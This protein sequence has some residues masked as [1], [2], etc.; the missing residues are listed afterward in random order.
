MTS[1][2]R[3]IFRLLAAIRVARCNQPGFFSANLT[4]IRPD[5]DLKFHFFIIIIISCSI[6]QQCLLEN[7]RFGG[8]FFFLYE[9]RLIL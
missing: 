6:Y 9:T 7:P 8:S 4:K 1:F 5:T 2:I 3:Y